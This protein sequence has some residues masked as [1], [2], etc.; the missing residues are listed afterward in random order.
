[1]KKIVALVLSLVMVLGLATTAFAADDKYDL[2]L[3]DAGMAA[4]ML[5]ADPDTDGYDDLTIDEVAAKT[6]KD[7]SG[8]VA[9]LKVGTMYATKTTAPTVASYAVCEAGKTTV[10]YYVDITTATSD[11]FF[12]YTAAVTAFNNFS[13]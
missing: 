6:N 12:K 8:N 1:M 3:A 13:A 10:L 11:D 9:Y 5:D 2:Y 4:D 7:G